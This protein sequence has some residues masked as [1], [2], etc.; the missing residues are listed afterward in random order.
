[1]AM[2]ERGEAAPTPPPNSPSSA[3]STP[4]FYKTSDLA[5]ILRVSPH[6]LSKWSARGWPYFPR[7][8]KL[9]NGEI[10]VRIERFEEWLEYW[11][12]R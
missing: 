7:H 9:P 2:K 6:T 12:N 1:M 4:S 5:S 11:E 8:M 10:R 3:A